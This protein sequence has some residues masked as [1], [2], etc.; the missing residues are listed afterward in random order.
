MGV[1]TGKYFRAFIYE[2]RFQLQKSSTRF[3]GTTFFILNTE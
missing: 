1:N 2:P 3:S